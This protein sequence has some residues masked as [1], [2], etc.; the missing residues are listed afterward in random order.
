M[1]KRVLF[2][3]LVFLSFV[4]VLPAPAMETDQYNLP[5]TPLVDIAPEVEAY[6]AQRIQLALDKLNAEI[7]AH[8]RCA[9]TRNAKPPTGGSNIRCGTPAFE[10]AKL[11]QL[12]S[13][14]AVAKAVYE[15]LGTGTIFHARMGLWLA[16]HKFEREPARYTA[17]FSES[18]YITA[19]LNYATLSPTIR[20]YGVEFGTDKFDHLIQ[21]GYTYYRKYTDAKKD[22]KSDTDALKKAVAWGRSTEN[23]FYGYAVSGVYSN[24]DLAANIAGLRFYQNLAN[25]VQLGD[26]TVPAI[27]KVI[28]GKWEFAGERAS[29]GVPAA[30]AASGVALLATPEAAVAGRDAGTPGGML[31][32][33]IS[34]HLNEALNPSNYLF[35][36]YPVVKS[37]VQKRACPEW[38]AAYPDLTRDELT[39]RTAAL[40]TWNGLDYGY[41][42]T[43]RQVRVADTCFASDKRSA[44]E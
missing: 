33:F 23:L 41:K 18:I 28:N 32:P 15:E 17:P 10:N 14:D 6:V 3:L 9:D 34:D 43:S 8:E 19:P 25:D 16:S 35:F 21:Q 1:V 11:A 44:A 2:V 27:L 40:T 20:V 42:K 30:A 31:R 26:T 36:L 38:R 24:A 4:G 5:P 22:G 7:A 29:T 12:R 37:V 13:P 39:R